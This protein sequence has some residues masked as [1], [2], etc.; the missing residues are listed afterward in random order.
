MEKKLKILKKINRE[1]V[2]YNINKFILGWD[3][4]D[5]ESKIKSTG[6]Y[7]KSTFGAVSST[8]YEYQQSAYD[9]Q[10]NNSSSHNTSYK[11]PDS[12]LVKKTILST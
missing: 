4:D 2:F 3:E 1:E 7:S 10:N 9:N 8:N 5:S 12:D 11:P 6:N